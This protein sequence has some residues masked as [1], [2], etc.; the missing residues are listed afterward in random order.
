MTA[1]AEPAPAT[2][3]PATE[4]PA[5]PMTTVERAEIDASTRGPV[6]FFLGNAILWLLAGTAL[7][8][9]TSIQLVRPTFLADIPF[10]TYGRLWPA[11]QNVMTYGWASLSGMGVAIWLM[12]RLTRVPIRFGGVLVAGA[13]LWQIGLT[14]GI[15][16]ILAGNSSGVEWLEIPTASAVLMLLGY[17]LVGLWGVMLYGLRKESTAYISVW[18]LLAAFLW[19]PW[20]FATAHL[21]KTYPL[22]SGVVQNIIAAWASQSFY[23]VWITAVGLATAYYL[24]PKVIN[25]PVYSYNVATAGFWAF[26]IFAGLTGATRLSGGP[27]PAWLVS[28][29]IAANILLLVQIVTVGVNL[30]LTMKGEER[31]VYHS[32]TVRFTYFGVICFLIASVLGLLSSLRSVDALVHFTPFFTGLQHLM[33]YGFF[34]M[35]I[36]GATYYIL[37]RLVGCEWLSSSLITFHFYGAAYGGSMVTVMLLLS[38]L[39]MGGTLSEPGTTYAQVIDSASFYIAGRTVAW[40]LV[41][42]GHLIFALHFALMLLRIGQPG[43]QPTL[44]ATHDEEAH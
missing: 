15:G 37:P 42:I 28:L 6:L 4:S 41:G 1:A 33:L 35:V 20:V 14:F 23:S 2:V 39:A 29:S 18:Y 32:P 3:T 36:F 7:G 10:L 31:F 25:R 24:I 26:I 27:I 40:T 17:A 9:I 44:F 19:F 8:F 34:S 43:G 11:Y 30:V 13:L 16:S 12:A 38:G 22:L 5:A 21:T